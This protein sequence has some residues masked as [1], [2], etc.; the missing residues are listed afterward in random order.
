MSSFNNLQEAIKSGG[1]YKD[2]DE[3]ELMLIKDANSPEMITVM[4][5]ALKTKTIAPDPFLKKVVVMAIHQSP[6]YI[7]Y[8]AL[9][10]RYGAD[11]NRYTIVDMKT[12][13]DSV[14]KVPI[15]VLKYIWD[16]TPRDI[17][18]SAMYDENI[19]GDV[20]DI[21][22]ARLKQKQESAI[23]ILSLMAFFGSS[24]KTMTITTET[25]VKPY[26]SNVTRF[27]IRRPNLWQ[28]VFDSIAEDG[29]LGAEA[30]K[31]IEF[32]SNSRY[33]LERYLGQ[34]VELEYE[35]ME[36][37][38]FADYSP[39]LLLQEKASNIEVLKSAFYYCDEKSI[40]G[41]IG[42]LRQTGVIGDGSP[43]AL[44]IETILLDLSL[45]NYSQ[46]GLESLM[47][48]GIVPTR[49]HQSQA[50]LKGK[51]LCVSN[52][53][54]C[55]IIAKFMTIYVDYGHG[56]DEEQLRSLGN[57]SPTAV[58]QIKAAYEKPYWTHACSVPDSK[59]D[60]QLLNLA[61]SVNIPVGASK[62]TI[63]RELKQ[64]AQEDPGKVITR[65]AKVQHNRFRAKAAS[66]TTKLS[67]KELVEP[68]VIP[69]NPI[70]PDVQ[71]KTSD[72]KTH[73]V[74]IKTFNPTP[75]EIKANEYVP[76]VTK[77]EKICSNQDS[78]ERDISDYSD[79]DIV[80][81][82]DG[83][84]T[85]CWESDIYE[86][87]I[88]SGGIN[89]RTGEPIAKSTLDEMKGKLALL[90]SQSLPTN[91]PSLSA[92]L[93]A[94]YVGNSDKTTLS[95]TRKSDTYLKDFLTFMEEDY[96]IPQS[97]FYSMSTSDIAEMAEYSLQ[98]PI[99]IDK[100]STK[101]TLKNFAEVFARETDNYGNT[102]DLIA[103]FVNQ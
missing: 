44:E 93:S 47:K 62:D 14:E 96:D 54:L 100:S 78:L 73:S 51:D 91:S 61:R 97:V 37:V 40:P 15:H 18:E 84:S 9:A 36:M 75:S 20:I 90:K 60:Q 101:T 64:I 38:Y 94:I 58:S 63:C 26:V 68:R 49:N 83:K 82:D 21:S 31:S 77:P 29:E 69:I 87:I 7:K 56:L 3:I 17:E 95:F 71:S 65:A 34:T 11:P 35:I 41:M 50:I 23:K 8:V 59:P 1:T 24:P 46:V 28:T 4:K 70:I 22:E 74:T 103:E 42:I 16:I 99:A 80:L 2:I 13:D 27:R 102:G 86:D 89:P 6:D 5:N 67:P 30:A 72:Y 45:E 57:Y 55:S 88:T 39:A 19:I 32:Y 25:M 53:L 12:L 10:L 92:G 48:N 33:N 81:D 98:S 66:F 85:W 79:I 43:E 52:I 76:I